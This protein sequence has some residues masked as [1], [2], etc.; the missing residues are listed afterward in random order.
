FDALGFPPSH[1]DRAIARKSVDKL[2][3]L[4][5]GDAYCQPCVS[6]VWDTALVCHTLLELGGREET[7]AAVRGLEWLQPLQ[8]LEVKGDW[9]DERPS[10]RPGGWA[11]QYRNDH[12]PDL[13]D[14]AA[15]VMAMDRAKNTGAD[16]ACDDAIARGREWVEGMQSRNG[17]WGAFDADNTYHYLNNIPFADHGALLDPPTPDVSA[18]CLG[19]P[20]P[21]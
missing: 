20:A 21:P 11:F 18:R 12:Y 7:A 5:E 2:L 15:V 14:T 1:P 16:L 6:P 13:D 9:A 4:R 3:V 10:T 17:G 19:L 8:V